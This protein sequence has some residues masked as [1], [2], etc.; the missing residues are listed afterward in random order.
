MRT[1]GLSMAL[2]ALTMALGCE[3]EDSCD[4]GQER[5]QGL[6]VPEDDEPSAGRGGKDSGAS[7]DAGAKTKDSGSG[8]DGGKDG[9]GGKDAATSKP[10]C[11]EERDAILGETCM[12]DDDCNC[13]A[14][15]CAKMPG[16]TMGFC[17]VFC[18]SEPDDC[19]DGYN[20]FDLAKIGVP[21]Y[22][23]FCVAE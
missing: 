4:A 6:C 3:A 22:E 2:I 16:Q 14:P 13:A 7:S 9:D 23:P 20:C 21:G 8:K 18:E 17:T 5:V 19:P 15:Y 11:S 12:S 1:I 10:A